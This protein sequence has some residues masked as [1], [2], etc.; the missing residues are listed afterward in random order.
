MPQFTWIV[1]LCGINVGGAGKLSMASLRNLLEGLGFENVRT[2]VQ[3]GNC[4][5]QSTSE[6]HEEVSTLI[7]QEIENRHEFRPSALA[8]TPTE[9]SAAINENP[10]GVSDK[11]SAKVHFFFFKPAPKNPNMFDL[12]SLKAPTESFDLGKLAFYLH[13]PEGIGRS[14]LA[15]KVE[16][17]LGVPT[18]ARNLKTVHALVDLA[19]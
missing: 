18:T 3:S 10:F 4:V 8:F 1:L 13:A 2:Y 17:S 16:K 11:E 19:Q 15:A 7:A 5:F 9:L 12:E 6:D 14:K